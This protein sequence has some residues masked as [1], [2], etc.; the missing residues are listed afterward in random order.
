MYNALEEMKLL[1]RCGGQIAGR[2][3]RGEIDA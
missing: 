1:H 2:R 3:I